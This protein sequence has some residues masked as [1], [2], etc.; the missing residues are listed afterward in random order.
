V[1][2][3]M[4]EKGFHQGVAFRMAG[5]KMPEPQGL[6]AMA[7]QAAPKAMSPVQPPPNPMIAGIGAGVGS[8]VGVGAGA[9]PPPPMPN[10]PPR[11]AVMPQEGYG[12]MA[13]IPR[14]QLPRLQKFSNNMA[15]QYGDLVARQQAQRANAGA[16][17]AADTG[18]VNGPFAPTRNP[19]G[20]LPQITGVPLAPHEM[21]GIQL[22]QKEQAARIAAMQAESGNAAKALESRTNLERSEAEKNQ[23]LTAG[24]QAKADMMKNVTPATAAVMENPNSTPDMIRQ[25]MANDEAMRR[26]N[27]LMQGGHL[28]QATPDDTDIYY[29]QLTGGDP[30]RD[31]HGALLGQR[32]IR[33]NFLS[34]QL[35]GLNPEDPEYAMVH[36]LMGKLFPGQ[37]T[38]LFY[39]QG[40]ERGVLPEIG[41]TLK[42][43]FYPQNKPQT[44]PLGFG[45]P[46]MPR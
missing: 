42:P 16:R 17:Y 6:M 29:R 46:A 3:A 31:A 34:R 23:A 25:S 33:Q 40:A 14:A 7:P 38:S 43:F 12:A 5:N 1:N 4:T 28:D 19:M 45:M 11:P 36:G 26:I 37:N 10:V 27:L 35:G 22:D 13:P 2:Q 44:M 41:Q 39:R 21:A 20:G 9:T 32:D 8:P 15:A 18:F 24:A 30:F